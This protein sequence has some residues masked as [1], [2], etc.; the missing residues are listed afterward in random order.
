MKNRFGGTFDNFLEKGMRH[1]TNINATFLTT[2]CVLIIVLILLEKKAV[3]SEK[4]A[5]NPRGGAEASPF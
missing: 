2:K 5:K 4:T 3:F 1:A